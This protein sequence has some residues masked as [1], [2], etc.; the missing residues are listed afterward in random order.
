M[1]TKPVECPKCG[2]EQLDGVECEA[3]GVIFAK[4]KEAREQQT[5]RELEQEESRQRLFGKFFGLIIPLVLAVAVTY[6]FMRPAP[7]SP[8]PA[9]QRPAVAKSRQASSAMVT[10]KS[11]PQQAAGEQQDLPAGSLGGSSIEQAR[12]A[13]VAIQTPWG[14]GSGFFI[15]RNCIVTS[16]HV[17]QFDP[18]EIASLRQKLEEKKKRLDSIKKNIDQARSNL[19]QVRS[20]PARQQWEHNIQQ[21]EQ[22]MQDELAQC[23]EAENQLNKMEQLDASD[24]T[25]T[26]VNGSSETPR[27][28][29]MSGKYD[30]AV[31]SLSA[32]ASEP[33]VLHPAGADSPLHPGDKLYA[34][35]TPVGLRN[36]VTAGI[37]SGYQKLG[38][39]GEVFLQ[40]DASINPGNSGGPLIDEKGFVRGVSTMIVHNTQG[41]GFAIPIERVFEELGP[42]IY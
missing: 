5:A 26:F 7:S 29:Q 24:I 4:Y 18:K 40:T 22:R 41:I 16:R 31:L 2:H 20:E 28:M 38:S 8:P 6:Y 17:V 35:G 13:T 3:C 32:S 27:S 19:S 1:G 12:N 15:S 39:E 30:L 10:E 11:E 21:N 14:I 34:V 36:T 23:A 9:N 42:Y 25:V 37:F 33:Q